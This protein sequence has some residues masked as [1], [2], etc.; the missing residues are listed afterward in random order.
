MSDITARLTTLASYAESA[1]HWTDDKR[2]M[3]ASGVADTIH[4]TIDHIEEL[5]AK[6]VRAAEVMR[7]SADLMDMYGL[8]GGLVADLRGTL[9][10]LT[11]ET[12]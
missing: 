6:L 11:G 5:E 8:S 2:L 4:S 3:D 1:N 12:K 7:R 9:A 10:E